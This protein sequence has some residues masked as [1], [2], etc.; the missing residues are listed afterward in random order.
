MHREGGKVLL[1]VT[2]NGVGVAVT[3]KRVDSTPFGISLIGLLTEKLKGSLRMLEG[4][5]YCV[6]IV[7]KE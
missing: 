3:E 5:G 4:L 2:D 6:E 1:V 7:F